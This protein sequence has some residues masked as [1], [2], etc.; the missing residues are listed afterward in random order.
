M[1]KCNL[2]TGTTICGLEL[3]RSRTGIAE[4][5][6]DATPM[7]EVGHSVTLVN[8]VDCQAVKAWASNR[9][10]VRMKHIL[11]TYMFA[12]DTGTLL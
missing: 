8:H 11:L 10:L 6:G 1:V 4:G 12:Q 2:V 9:G 5:S 3:C 7:R